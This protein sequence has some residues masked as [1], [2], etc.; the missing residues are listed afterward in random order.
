MFTLM[1]APVQECVSMPFKSGSVQRLGHD[2]RRVELS[3]N[4]H[5]LN[6][7]AVTQDLHPLLLA[8]DVPEL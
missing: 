5:T 2:V 6:K 8:V 7:V 3:R 1:W 4:M